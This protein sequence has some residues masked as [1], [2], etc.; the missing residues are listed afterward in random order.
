MEALRSLVSL[1]SADDPDAGSN[2]P[3]PNLRKAARL[4]AQQPVLVAAYEAARRGRPA[5]E[6]DPE[7]GWRPTSCSRSPA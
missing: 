1:A 6:P 7:S 4:T 5:R 2:D 3:G